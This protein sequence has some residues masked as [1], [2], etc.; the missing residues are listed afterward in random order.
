MQRYAENFDPRILG[1]SGDRAAIDR[2][3]GNF[4][5][6]ARKT[7]GANGDSA[8]DHRAVIIRWTA[9]ANLYARSIWSGPPNRRRRS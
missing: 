7:P 1:L 6:D 4:R 9:T 5:F 3:I 2:V 8:M